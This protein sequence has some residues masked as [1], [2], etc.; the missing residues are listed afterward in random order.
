MPAGVRDRRRGAS[1]NS[2][3]AALVIAGGEPGGRG[4]GC[5]PQGWADL[6]RGEPLD[7]GHLFPAPGVTALVT[8]TAVLRLVAEGRFGL[9]SPA[10]DHLRAVRLAD[11]T[12]TVRELLSHPPGSTTPAPG[13]CTPTRVPE[14]AELMGPVVGCGGPR[15]MVQPS[16]GGCAVLGQLVAD[17]TGLPYAAAATALV[18]ARW[19]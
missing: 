7:P 9:D 5:W 13:R 15:G 3:C 19:T 18:L 8:A 12:I 16:N 2:A 11:D 17:V 14:L 1:P 4:R 6:D 10:N